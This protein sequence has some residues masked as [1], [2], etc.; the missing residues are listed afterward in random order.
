MKST[1]LLILATGFTTVALL[2]FLHKRKY[3]LF[4]RTLIP[5]RIIRLFCTFKNDEDDDDTKLSSTSLSDDDNEEELSNVNFEDMPQTDDVDND[6]DDDNGDDFED[7]NPNATENVE[8]INS[9]VT[10]GIENAST[11]VLSSSTESF[12]L[13]WGDTSSGSSINGERVT[14]TMESG[15]K[16]DT[17][18]QQLSLNDQLSSPVVQTLLTN[19]KIVQTEDEKPRRKDD[20]PFLMGGSAVCEYIGRGYRHVV[21]NTGELNVNNSPV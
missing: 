7:K 19:R 17:D 15:I 20:F 18:K 11:C 9:E 1:K 5:E 8:I 3:I 10:F 16:V 6:V 12:D 2:W 4:T 14:Q 13:N 21:S